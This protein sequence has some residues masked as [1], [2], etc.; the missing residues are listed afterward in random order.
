MGLL[1]K[2]V[3]AQWTSLVGFTLLLGRLFGSWWIDSRIASKSRQETLRPFGADLASLAVG[4][5]A[6]LLASC[7]VGYVMTN[8]FCFGLAILIWAATWFAPRVAGA[9][10]HLDNVVTVALYL[11]GGSYIF[12][13]VRLWV[14]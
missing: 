14:Q 11:G 9:E 10:E 7:P 5:H 1:D 6:G 2:L 4:L 12:A 3:P 8:V 13:L